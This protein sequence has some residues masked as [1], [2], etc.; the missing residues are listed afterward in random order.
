MSF[1]KPCFSNK[2]NQL[3]RI[4]FSNQFKIK[5]GTFNRNKTVFQKLALIRN[6]IKSITVKVYIN[7]SSTFQNNLRLSVNIY[8]SNT[9]SVFIIGFKIQLVNC[10]LRFDL[11]E[12]LEIPITL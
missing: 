11:Q 7:S 6:N 8:Y 5:R 12:Y 3:I 1:I 2:S 10:S 4:I 9:H